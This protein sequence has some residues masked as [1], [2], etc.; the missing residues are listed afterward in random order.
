M[1]ALS[2]M[3][4]QRG[5]T[6]IEVLVTMLILMVGVLGAVAL[7]D[8]A[9]A[10][11][12]ANKEREGANALTREVIEAARSVPYQSLNPTSAVTTIKAIPGLADTTPG[13]VP[14]TVE[15]RNQ[16][17]TISL[18]VC[19]V[20]DDQDGFG[21]TT[22]GNF[23][24]ASTSTADRNPDDYKRLSVTVTWT[25]NGVTRNVK[26]AGVVN[27]EA[28]ATGPAVEFTSQSPAGE[29][30]T[31]S[32][33]SISFGAQA[34]TGAVAIR[35]SVDGVLVDTK[36]SATATFTWDIDSAA[37]HVPDGTYVVSVTAF[38]AESVPGPTR[39]RT[40]R[41]NR[42]LP[43]APE[44]VFG[45]WNSRADFTDAQNI[46]EIQWAR[47]TEPDVT[48]YRVYR[49]LASGDVIV[50]GCDKPSEPSFTD[51]RDLTPPA[52]ATIQYYVKALDENPSTGALREGAA[53]ATLTATR[54]TTKPNQAATL[55]ITDDGDAAVLDWDDAPA[56]SPAYSGSP[57]I[58]Y[59]VY[60]DGTAIGDR[61]ARTGQDSLT[62][63][64]DSDGLT[65]THVYYVTS[66]DTNFSES[67]PLGPVALP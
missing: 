25:R 4:G 28:S 37:Q 62:A 59:R 66:V 60:R 35:F 23:C 26:Q 10:R 17:Y 61:I 27:N 5:F 39:A 16:T 54:A 64:R 63:F 1:R 3:R 21:T 8:G 15:R 56:A 38:N 43:A 45:G 18:S 19:S 49:K 51:C 48:G 30:I 44:D 40:I 7:I 11:T 58:F 57:V 41:L 6:L 52:G 9:S 55:S 2:R 29:E 42:D 34:A 33:S 36:T 22:T 24:S 47:N 32:P 20:D 14:W 67:A 12:V 46:V 53:S 31:S 50:P 13:T 65:G